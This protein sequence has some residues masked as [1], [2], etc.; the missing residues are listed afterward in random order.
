MILLKSFPRANTRPYYDWIQIIKQHKK[1]PF[2]LPRKNSVVCED[3]FEESCFYRSHR[4]LRL[5]N[6][7]MPTL[8][9][10]NDVHK[11][12]II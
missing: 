2:F 8:F 7:S 1:K 6:G 11:E 10:N 4:R 5:Q 9:I 3:H 12:V